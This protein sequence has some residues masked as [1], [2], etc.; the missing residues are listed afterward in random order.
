[1]IKLRLLSIA[2]VT[3][4]ASS[5]ASARDVGVDS[6]LNDVNSL[7]AATAA[8][9]PG[10][11]TVAGI[12]VTSSQG[13]INWK[14]VK[15]AGRGFAYIRH[16]D[17]LALDL[18]RI[19]NWKNASAEGL[20]VGYY[21]RF[22]PSMDPVEQ[23]KQVVATLNT[24][25]GAARPNLPPALQVDTNEGQ[26][27]ATVIA[28]INQWLA[29]IQSNTG[30]QPVLL[31]TSAY[32]SSLGAPTPSPLPY[33]WISQLNVACP[34]VPLPWRIL[35]FWQSSASGSVSGISGFVNLDT[36]NGSLTALQNL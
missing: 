4:L 35:R 12:D 21:Q 22:R 17:G 23:A 9:C 13:S 10:A 29:Y 30:R 36:Y 1:M 24:V 19:T 18:Y 7:Q 2:L 27:S 16:S 34:T 20:T 3:V 33:V 32:W 31:V 15:A 28:R 26:S 25:S 5:D 11:T 14:S 8:T 6:T